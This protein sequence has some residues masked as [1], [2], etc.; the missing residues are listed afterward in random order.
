MYAP[1]IDDS[2]DKL[3]QLAQ[4]QI[5][6]TLLSSLALRATP[7]SAFVSSAVTVILFVVPLIGVALE[8]PLF[9]V[10]GKSLGVLMHVVRK[11]FPNLKPPELK[12]ASVQVKEKASVQV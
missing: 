3:S 6:L 4:L 10:M 7:P 9:E 8:T 1:F 2:D 11:T 12:Q 5:F